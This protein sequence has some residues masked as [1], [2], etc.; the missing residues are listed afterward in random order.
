MDD[1]TLTK[2]ELAGLRP[3]AICRRL[4]GERT[5]IREAERAHGEYEQQLGHPD[6]DWPDW[7]AAYVVSKLQSR[8]KPEGS[9][10]E[11][12]A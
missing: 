10:E 8:R 6:A 7:H 9:G 3:A 1:S 12:R 2:D 5:C 4:R 11:S